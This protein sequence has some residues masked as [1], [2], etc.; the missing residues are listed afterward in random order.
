M[1]SRM[2]VTAKYC[3]FI[4]KYNRRK[5][6]G[7]GMLYLISNPVYIEFHENSFPRVLLP[8]RFLAYGFGVLVS[9]RR[10][11][12]RLRSAAELDQSIRANTTAHVRISPRIDMRTCSIYIEQFLRLR[13]LPRPLRYEVQFP[14]VTSNDRTAA[15]GL[16]Q[17]ARSSTGIPLDECKTSR[18]RG[19]DYP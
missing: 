4:F 11:G 10:S 7:G 16:L 3:S 8:G 5:A 12:H 9:R 13:R 14:V 15:A 19:C 2:N 6:I 17:T 18:A 1:E